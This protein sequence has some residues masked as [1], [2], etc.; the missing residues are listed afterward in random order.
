MRLFMKDPILW[1]EEKNGLGNLLIIR[2]VFVFL[3]DVAVSTNF[4]I[5]ILG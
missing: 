1:A 3:I 2:N 4:I 5:S